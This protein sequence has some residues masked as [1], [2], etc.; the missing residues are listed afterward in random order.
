VRFA[1]IRLAAAAALAGVVV[2]GGLVVTPAAHAAITGS[3]I[4][5][6]T[7]PT[8][9]LPDNAAS[10]AFTVSGTTTGSTAGDEVDIR[11]YFDATD[12]QTAA[13]NVP[14]TASGSFS[15]TTASL[16]LLED[17]LCQLR[18]VPAGSTPSDLTP[19]TG[20]TI[21][22]GERDDAP[23]ADGPNSGTLVDYY[24]WAQQSTGAFDYRSLG[25]C[26][27]FDGYLF[28]GLTLTTITYY[29]DAAL[30][31]ATTPT[32]SSTRS[33]A[34][35]DGADAYAPEAA[36]LINPDGSGLPAL[37]DSYTVDPG[38]GDL[39]L[40]ETD[41]LVKCANATYPPTP[42]SCAT[43]VS[44]GVTDH[45][46]I[47]QGHDGHISWISDAFTST[48]GKSHSLDLLWDNSQHFWGGSS[49]DSTQVEYRFPGQSAFSIPTIG[50]K[51]SL[52]ASP[53]TILVRMHGAADGDT[54]TGQGAIVYDRPAANATFT[55]LDTNYSEFTLRQTG[56]VPARGSTTFRFAYVQD[57]H[58]A[59]VAS[60]AAAA[61]TAFLDKIAVAKSGPGKGKV[62]SSPG[63]IACGSAC[64]HSYGYG[65]SVTLKAKAAAGS[66][67]S[68]FSGACKGT[69]SCKVKLTGDAAV[70]AK[71]VLKPCIVPNLE[72][73]TL[74]AA[75]LAIKKAFCSLG[76][77]ET[78]ASSA[79]KGRVVSQKPQHGRRVKQHT[80]IALA[81]SAG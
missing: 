19:F 24:L 49:G 42:T 50:Q 72:G 4:T 39:V 77:V 6:P 81:V 33:E 69:R 2:V 36:A 13:S 44:V 56:T 52:P 35:V 71:F 20:P 7:S 74:Q 58:A 28:S 10:L 60:M 64:T 40:H 70:K 78:V 27:L 61:H 45:R 54:A 22:V 14:V 57:Y 43:F 8:F 9:F 25:F 65:T 55:F 12:Y 53:G 23:L 41:P 80:K 38:S 21:G 3:T 51:V 76:K 30:L 73:K 11:C 29:C 32:S 37:T 67:F 48:D 79:A 31:Q 18:A 66:K 46:T 47:T 34:Q 1:T 16:G 75:K 63:G 62:T 5:A 26:G 68:G 17:S 15:T 59:N